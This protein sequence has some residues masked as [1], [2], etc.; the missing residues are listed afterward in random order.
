M[1]THFL[2]RTD[3]EFSVF[4][5]F[6]QF[7]IK[8]TLS[9]SSEGISTYIPSSSVYPFEPSCASGQEELHREEQDAVGFPYQCTRQMTES[10]PTA[11]PF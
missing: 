6:I 10:E 5:L 7:H 4:Y 9:G 3:S 8:N 2:K 1:L 11:E